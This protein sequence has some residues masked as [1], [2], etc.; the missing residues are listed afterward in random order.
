MNILLHFNTIFELAAG[1][2]LGDQPAGGPGRASPS[3]RALLARAV[4]RQLMAPARKAPVHR[5]PQQCG[6]GFREAP[7]E[8]PFRY[9]HRSNSSIV[10]V[11]RR[12]RGRIEEAKAQ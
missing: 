8:N 6:E 12:Y 2:D 5:A 4:F 1:D 3:G 10:F 7:A 9:S 11:R